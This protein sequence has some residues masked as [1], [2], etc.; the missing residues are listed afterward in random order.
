MKKCSVNALVAAIGPAHAC[1][2][3]TIS[4]DLPFAGA[5]V[6]DPSV[7]SPQSSVV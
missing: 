4:P 1:F 7:G 3:F 6:A 2:L 5:L